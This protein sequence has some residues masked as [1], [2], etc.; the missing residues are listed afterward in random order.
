MAKIISASID[1]SKIDKSKLVEGKN[2]AKYLNLTIFCNDSKDQYD[3]DVAISEGQTKEEREAKAKKHYLGNGKTI[4]V[5]E[6]EPMPAGETQAPASKAKAS[7][8]LPF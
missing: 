6:G 8:S 5:S 1:V 2:G 3:H 7:D 4:W